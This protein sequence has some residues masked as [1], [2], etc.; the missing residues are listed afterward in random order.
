MPKTIVTFTGDLQKLFAKFEADKSRLGRMV[1]R[2][3]RMLELNK[4]KNVTP[5]SSAAFQK[6]VKQ[7][8]GGHPESVSPSADGDEGSAFEGSQSRRDASLRPSAPSPRHAGVGR[9]TPLSM[10]GSAVVCQRFP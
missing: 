8:S 9:R 2:V 10:T 4:R 7:C 1:A 3:E 6:K 5:G